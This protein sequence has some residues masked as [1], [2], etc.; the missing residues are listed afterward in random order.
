MLRHTPAVRRALL[1]L[2]CALALG[3]CGGG[4]QRPQ[5]EA[6]TLVLDRPPNAVHTGIYTALARDFDGAE[7]VTLRVRAPSSPADALRLLQSNRADFAVLGIADL[8]LARAG[9]ED[10]VGV[11]ALVQQPLA[12]V[13]ADRS[14]RSPRRLARR[15]VGVAGRPGDRG[16]LRA[17]AGRAEA[18]DVGFDAAR[19]LL[20]GRVEAVLG[21]WSVEGVALRR[22]RE[23][24]IEELG[25]PAYP[26][27]VLCVRRETFRDDRDVVD[28][29][30]ATLR[31]GYE[32]AL[33]DPELAVEALVR[34]ERR[35][36]RDVVLAQL[37]AL[38]A[39][40]TAGASRFG[41]LERARL[42]AWA[43]W[44]ERTGLVERRLDVARAFALG[45]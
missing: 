10:L 28:A 8:A 26:E 17:L 7:G 39:A 5:G 32:E 43:S 23:F 15:R 24:R 35:A 40:F 13:L 21:F 4:G 33:N 42:Q 11:M 31:R 2:A 16:L 19:A 37:R 12:A 27:L 25:A 9:G 44:A 30:L 22:F 3:S 29:V 45:P 14:I 6:A 1:L 20:R 34:R 41:V 38:G 36:E 18:V